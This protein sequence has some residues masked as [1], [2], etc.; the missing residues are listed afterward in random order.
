LPT[1]AGLST[2]VEPGGASPRLLTALILAAI[3]VAPQVL[4]TRLGM[5]I[6]I[7]GRLI[8]VIVAVALAAQ[9]LGRR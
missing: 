4:T 6:L 3:A 5:P 7:D 2:P 1:A 8:G 9:V